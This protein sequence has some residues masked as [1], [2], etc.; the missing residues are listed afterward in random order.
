MELA[1]KALERELIAFCRSQIE[2]YK[3]PRSVEFTAQ[4]PREPT[5]KLQRRLL[6]EQSRQ[7]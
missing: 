7:L 5:G 2:E 1:G 4:L 6:R 3:C